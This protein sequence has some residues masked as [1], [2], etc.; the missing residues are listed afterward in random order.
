MFK[1]TLTAL[2]F[3]LIGL[4]PAMAGN[5]SIPS[6]PQE[7]AN[8]GNLINSL[9]IS[10]N[11]NWAPQGGSFVTTTIVS[12]NAAATVSYGTAIGPSGL[13]PTTAVS[14]LKIRGYIN[15]TT[16]PTFFFIP[17]WGCPTCL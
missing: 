17:L 14:W 3:L 9:I 7:P 2:A 8:M 6:G 5:V 15:N 1:K 11:N 10:G 12:A 13:S 4:V 16:T